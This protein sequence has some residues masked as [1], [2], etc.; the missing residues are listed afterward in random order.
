MKI[1]SIIPARGGSKTLPRKNIKTFNGHPLIYWS[2][3]PSV[4]AKSVGKTI[5]STDD[6]EIAETAKRYG[7]IV[8]FLRPKALAQ[9]T[10]S[11]MSLVVHALDYFEQQGEYFDA[12][13][14]LQPTSPLRT[15]EELNDM[16]AHFEQHQDNFD[17]LVAVIASL[18]PPHFAKTIENQKL[19]PLFPE[20]KHISRRQDVPPSF[21]PCGMAY[22]TKVKTIRETG[23]FYPERTLG[24]VVDDRHRYDIDDGYAFIAAEGVHKTCYDPKTQSYKKM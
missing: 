6:E 7:N 19:I 20:F 23:S 5:V 24:W 22:L 13:L 16:I 1:L 12:V 14:L 10:S 11:S 18:A 8:P 9:D 3:L 4:N 15:A 21:T 17:S 2:I